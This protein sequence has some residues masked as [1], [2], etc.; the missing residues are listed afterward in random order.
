MCVL[1]PQGKD[2]WGTEGQWNF[3]GGEEIERGER[4]K[5]GRREREKKEEE[6][7]EEKES[8]SC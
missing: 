5:R 3:V 8:C 1:G 2:L 6:A 4:E 7:E